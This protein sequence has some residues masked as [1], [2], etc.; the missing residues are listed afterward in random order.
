[1]AETKPSSLLRAGFPELDPPQDFAGWFPSTPIE[2]REALQEPAIRVPPQRRTGPVR[3]RP[4]DSG[5]GILP[6][7]AI[8][9]E[10]S[11]LGFGSL[12]HDFLAGIEWL[13]AALPAD[14]PAMVVA[15]L[16]CPEV[17][18]LFRRPSPAAIVW[19]ERAVAWNSGGA[20]VSAQMDRVVIGEGE[21]VVIDFKT[22]QGEPAAIAA[23]Y[24]SQMQAYLKILAAWSD[25]RH[26]LRAVVATVRTPAVIEIPTE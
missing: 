21:I 20:I 13:P 1:M 6:G 23:R 7:A 9:S 10:S 11:G 3:S 15:F 4:S 26:R 2:E 5:H 8:F 17:Q 24:A 22:D 16:E 14:T 12:V 25:G 19:R 18:A